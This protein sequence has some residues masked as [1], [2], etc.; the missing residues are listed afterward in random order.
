MKKGFVAILVLLLLITVFILGG[1]LFL[2][3]KRQ[4]SAG[5]QTPTVNNNSTSFNNQ[6]VVKMLDTQSYVIPDKLLD[7]SSWQLYK[8]ANY[9]IKYP[10]SLEIE[11]NTEVIET[12]RFNKK[13][14]P[15]AAKKAAAAGEPG[16]TGEYFSVF[17]IA[18]F[19]IPPHSTIQT[20]L[21]D[22]DLMQVHDSEP[23]FIE[24]FSFNGLNGYYS[25]SYRTDSPTIFIMN[26]DK[27][28]EIAPIGQGPYGYFSE[29]TAYS[30][31]STLKF[32]SSGQ[33]NITWLNSKLAWDV[34]DNPVPK[35]ELQ[36][37]LKSLSKAKLTS[38]QNPD[39]YLA[40]TNGKMDGDWG[41]FSGGERPKPPNT[42]QT[43]GTLILIVHK[44]NGVWTVYEGDEVDFCNVVK[45]VPESIMSNTSK[46]YFAECRS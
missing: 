40:I 37:L 2:K 4:L 17:G 25:K 46:N 43:T 1:T 15:E 36:P 44:N 33:S 38:Y 20:V 9:S 28:Y 22:G 11:E 34:E 7:T 30:M 16:A 31:L 10:P 6:N 26:N 13:G 27:L 24:N 42:F 14:V 21:A 18:T 41:V 19:N 32:K 12:T 5:T 39:T 45:A 29:D 35:I 8:N 23:T 3:H